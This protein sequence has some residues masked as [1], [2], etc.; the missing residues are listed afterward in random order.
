[1]P[2]INVQYD[3]S[4]IPV[5]G[6]VPESSGT[7]PTAPADGQLWHD[8]TNNLLKVYENGSWQTL[9]F[10]GHT[11]AQYA[12]GITTIS[13]GTG[14]LGGGDLS[15]NRTLSVDF[16]ASGTTST[17]KAVRADDSRLSD[18]RTPTTHSHAIADLP[19]ATSGTSNATQLV[20][21]DDSRL[22]NARTPSGA[23]G[24]S[25]TGT[26]PNPTIANLAITDAMVAAAN[27]DG[28]AGTA[29]MRTLGTGAQ[30]AMAGN[31]RLDQIAAP[32]AAVSLNSQR[33]TNVADPTAN[34]D[35][36]NKQYVD[37]ARAGLRIKDAVRVATTANITLSGTQTI[38]S[39]AVVAGDRVLVKN[40]TTASANGIYIVAA[41]AWTRA[42]DADAAAEVSD[43]AT[44]FVQQGSQADTTWAQINTITTLGTD[45]QSWVQQG[46]AASYTAGAGLTQTG[47]TFDVV[48][49][50][51]SITVSADS[52]T[53]GNVPVTKGGTGATTATAAR[54]NLGAV[55]KFAFDLG[56]LTAGVESTVT[57]SLGSVDV[58]A[59]VKNIGTGYFEE[60][61]IRVID[62]N[63]IGITSHIAYAANTYRV[64]VAA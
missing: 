36:A 16:A 17:T 57:H 58:V 14:L 25:L 26:Y 37:A 35:A 1:M 51:G 34:T 21:A 33:I 64:V 42:T 24:G 6:L 3:F 23:A 29:S 47:N 59:M 46:A 19:V 12:L 43:G 41:G 52:I 22:S 18:A 31:T 15:A 11:H 28:V 5:K 4:K 7:A 9:S 56:A 63:S 8:S 2:K 44:T 62:A 45:N 40:Q 50:D 60:F 61:D 54:T 13:A 10:D 20:R 53:V 39:V 32:T 30:Q 48:A 49:A 27:K 38:D 55:G